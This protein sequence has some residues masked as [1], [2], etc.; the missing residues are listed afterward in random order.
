MEGAW[1]RNYIVNFPQTK[2]LPNKTTKRE[3]LKA[4]TIAS[5]P[6]LQGTRP[7]V[8]I[9]TKNSRL[10][11]SAGKK[12]VHTKS[13]AGFRAG[14][15]VTNNINI[16]KGKP[17]IPSYRLDQTKDIDSL[18]T[19][20]LGTTFYQIEVNDF[21]YERMD[22]VIR[23]MNLKVLLKRE[24]IL[25]ARIIMLEEAI[26][27][28]EWKMI[29]ELVKTLNLPR[30]IELFLLTAIVYK[31]TRGK[32]WGKL[33]VI[34]EKLYPEDRQKIESI[35]EGYAKEHIKKIPPR[36]RSKL[37]GSGNI[38]KKLIGLVWGFD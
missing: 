9:K 29:K 10:Y 20:L 25:K 7:K 5:R 38:K 8:E 4:G 36:E 14:I 18:I 13:R 22:A 19:D 1:F 34:A 17:E 26:R 31:I 21:K 2:I 24:D 33:K 28:K 37:R 6:Q 15:G 11:P 27:N 12:L 3:N 23:L 16:F 30:D 35:M 32:P